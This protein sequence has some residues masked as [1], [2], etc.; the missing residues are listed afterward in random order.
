MQTAFLRHWNRCCLFVKRAA[1]FHSG[2]QKRMSSRLD[3]LV[4]A[5]FGYDYFL[6]Y[7]HDDPPAYAT[8]L[9]QALRERGFDVHLDTRDYRAGNNLDLLTRRRVRN[10][11][12]LVVIGQPMALSRSIW[13]RNEVEIFAAAGKEPV[14]I[15]VDGSVAVA[16]RHPRVG[17]LSEWLAL[18]RKTHPTGAIQDPILRIV[19]DAGRASSIAR[20]PSAGTVE[21]IIDRFRG[22]RV[23]ARR[24]RVVRATMAVLLAL[25]VG[26]SIAAFTAWENA[27]EAE[28]RGQLALSRQ[29]ASDAR[30]AAEAPSPAN[31]FLDRAMLLAVRS[32]A[33]RHTPEGEAALASVMDRAGWLN[34][35][36]YNGSRRPIWEIAFSPDDKSFASLAANGEIAAHDSETLVRAW[37]ART[38]DEG[39]EV[40]ASA[41]SSTDKVRIAIGGSSGAIWL[42]VDAACQELDKAKHDDSARPTAIKFSSDGRQL[43]VGRQSG[44]LDLFIQEDSKYRRLVLTGHDKAIH[45]LSFA[46]DGRR[47]ASAQLDGLILLRDIDDGSIS[48]QYKEVGR[49]GVVVYHLFFDER[50][51]RLISGGGGGDVTMWPLEKGVAEV[52]LP[53]HSDSILKLFAYRDLLFVSD[54]AGNFIKWNLSDS[55]P[56]PTILSQG[57]EDVW[58]F[59]LS[60]D[61]SRLFSLSENGDVRKWEIEAVPPKSD[62]IGR[63]DGRL[64]SFG[65]TLSLNGSATRLVTGGGGGEISSWRLSK[66]SPLRAV[67]NLDFFGSDTNFSSAPRA[68]GGGNLAVVSNGSVPRLL[69]ASRLDTQSVQTR[70]VTLPTTA[71]AVA[72]SPNGQYLV[73]GY[74]DGSLG[75]FL[76][77][78]GRALIGPIKAE[79]GPIYHV[80]IDD[81]GRTAIAVR[82]TLALNEGIMTIIRADDE[83]TRIVSVEPTHSRVNAVAITSDGSTAFSTHADGTVWKTIT[84]D[85][86]GKSLRLFQLGEIANSIICGSKDTL[87]MAMMSGRI[88]TADPDDDA[89]VVEEVGRQERAAFSLAFSPDGEHL[90]SVDLV[91][92]LA[93][94]HVPTRRL[95]REFKGPGERAAVAVGYADDGDHVVAMD[96]RNELVVWRLDPNRWALLSCQMAARSLSASE[97][98]R[99]PVLGDGIDPC[100]RDLVVD[101]MGMP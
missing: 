56:V 95:I 101:R 40:A 58:D 87:A 20:F 66:D 27:Q 60:S 15:D 11:K 9:D 38:I 4:D 8:A 64:L 3:T 47:L 55:E 62:L 74:E 33:L 16:L 73:V 59:A 51:N 39:D 37:G 28:D 23:A 100:R 69:I 61:G 1:D 85:D 34:G 82:G 81:S 48:M 90:I 26:A 57:S 49:T 72:F 17:T 70:S 22:D 99:Y 7:S 89:P 13:V 97:L 68:V 35:Y 29:L 94:W 79:S 96:D 63:H 98:A 75:M 84:L 41:I 83:Q 53:I 45:A 78:E 21:A 93:L 77:A 19:D 18:N 43:A 44:Q 54:A 92:N 71:S 5:L 25:A 67:S 31:G 76:V 6:S 91:N 52:R 24:K 12:V 30:L 42:C 80:A 32:Y 65:S 50:H 2:V 36:A 88:Y 10:S 14:I 46:D 86:S